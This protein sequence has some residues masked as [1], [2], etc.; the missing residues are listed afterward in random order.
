MMS[1]AEMLQGR[2][3]VLFTKVGNVGDFTSKKVKCKLHQPA[4][5]SFQF[6]LTLTLSNYF[7]G[8]ACSSSTTE[9]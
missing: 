7:S 8:L 9:G 3:I 2:S 4:K 5:N 6:L 1:A